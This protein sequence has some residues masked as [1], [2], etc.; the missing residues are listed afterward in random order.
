MALNTCKQ[1]T[2]TVTHTETHIFGYGAFLSKFLKTAPVSAFDQS[3][4]SWPEEP[5]IKPN[6]V[7]A[8]KLMIS[9]SRCD[10]FLPRLHKL[11]CAKTDL[12]EI[13]AITVIG[14]TSPPPF[15]PPNPRHAH[16]PFPFPTYVCIFSGSLLATH[17]CCDH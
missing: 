4:F 8:L 16:T 5:F 11:G 2:N 15:P 9:Q 7:L 1:I 17:K 14:T 6:R 10:V 3:L 13:D 12:L